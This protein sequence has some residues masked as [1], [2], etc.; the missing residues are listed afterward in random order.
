MFLKKGG[1]GSR[2]TNMKNRFTGW[3]VCVLL[4]CGSLC[5]SAVLAAD[6]VSSASAALMFPDMQMEDQFRVP[7][8]HDSL[9]SSESARP[10]ILI[11]GDQRRTD[12]NIRAW[13]DLLKGSLG[14][15]VGYIGMANLRGLP[16]FVSK[17]SVR[18]SLKKKLPDVPVL[19]DWNGDGFKKFAFVRRQTN[20]YIYSRTR[21]LVGSVTGKPDDENAKAVI[22]LVEL[23]LTAK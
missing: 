13:V 2:M 1:L 9:F 17:N 3:F 10:L 7:H 11:A 4:V 20:V 19:C 14:D 12:D 21:S 18:S 15:R 16:F 6:P 23:A 5:G 22:S 8:T